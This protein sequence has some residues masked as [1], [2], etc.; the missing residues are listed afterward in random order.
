MNKLKKRLK[1][2]KKTKRISYFLLI[3]IFIFSIILSSLFSSLVTSVNK[4][5]G[6]ISIPNNYFYSDYNITKPQF[7]IGFSIK[8]EG[9]TKISSLRINVSEDIVYFNNFTETRVNIF[10]KVLYIGKVGPHTL[11]S[12]III[13]EIN[14][15]KI[16]ALEDYWEF[17]NASLG[18]SEYLNIEIKCKFFYGLIPFK[19]L[20]GPLCLS[21]LG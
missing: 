5:I 8:N 18:V 16:N 3:I 6:S 17:A 19:V 20:I 15:F 4:T 9:F 21:C 12:N 10:Q 14:N 7:E 2:I 13:G 11:Y 1:N